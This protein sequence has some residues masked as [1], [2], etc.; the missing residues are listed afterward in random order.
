VCGRER[1][2]KRD[3]MSGGEKKERDRPRGEEGGR[4]WR[5]FGRLWARAFRRA[6]HRHPDLHGP[7][8][9]AGVQGVEGRG[10]ARREGPMGG[11]A[12]IRWPVSLT[13]LTARARSLAK[14]THGGGMG[15]GLAGCGP[16]PGVRG[17]RGVCVCERVLGGGGRHAP[18]KGVRAGARRPPPPS[19]REQ[20]ETPG[21][22]HT[23]VTHTGPHTPS[24]MHAPGHT[25]ARA[26]S[27]GP[28]PP[29][30]RPRTHNPKPYNPLSLKKEKEKKNGVF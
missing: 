23:P 17:G 12:S 21:C 2:K 10:L 26:H 29:R 3:G 25:R 1:E 4:E 9:E 13:P 15:G 24:H 5:A 16:G 30:T 14:R 27:R 8:S 20:S 18:S 19:S 6:A 7:L 11:A 28:S 22:A